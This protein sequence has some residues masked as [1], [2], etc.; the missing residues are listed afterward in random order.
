MRDDHPH[1]LPA[2]ARGLDLLPFVA[3]FALPFAWAFWAMGTPSDLTATQ[4][5]ASWWFK[6]YLAV[7]LYAPAMALLWIGARLARRWHRPGVAVMLRLVRW[8]LF[9]VVYGPILFFI[10]AAFVPGLRRL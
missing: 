4:I 2:L 8:A 3:V 6:G 10:A 5:E 9:L 1:S 7:L